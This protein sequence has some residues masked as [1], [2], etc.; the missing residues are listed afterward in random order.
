[1]L[2]K[3]QAIQKRHQ[4]TK[5][6]KGI[7]PAFPGNVTWLSVNMAGDYKRAAGM[8]IHIGIGN[9]A[10]GKNLP[11]AQISALINIVSNSNVV[12]F[13]PFPGRT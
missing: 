4:L 6:L 10:G 11:D 7:Y 9:L 3:R 1:V 5:S 8:A 13:L 12:Q 2:N